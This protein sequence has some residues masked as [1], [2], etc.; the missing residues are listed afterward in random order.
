MNDKKLFSLTILG[1]IILSLLVGCTE[2]EKLGDNVTPPKVEKITKELTRHGDTRID[3]YYWLNERENPK[4]INYLEAENAYR[5]TVMRLTENLQENLYREIV[6]RIKQDDMSVPYLDNGYYY[7]SRYEKGKEYPIYARKKETLQADEEITLNVPEIAKGHDYYQVSGLNVSE[8]NNLIA[9]GV[10]TVSRR[11][12]DIYFKDLQNGKLL[13]DLLHNTS[14]YVVWA[15]DNKT[16]FY[17]IKDET[18][19]PHKL[20]K[21]ILGQDPAKDVMVF[22]EKDNTFSLSVSKT[23]TNKFIEIGSSHTLSTEVNLIDANHPDKPYKIFQKRE[24][25]HEYTIYHHLDKFYILTNWMAKNFRL[26]ETEEGKTDKKY[27]I[28]VLP[29]HEDILLQNVTVFKDYLALG[30]RKNGIRQLHVMNL[31]DQSD[32][33]LEFDEESY[34]V[35][36]STNRIFDTKTLRYLY[37]SMTTPGSTFDYDMTS[38]E[39]TLLKREEVGGEFNPDDYRSERVWAVAR[40]DTKVPISLV[41]HRNTKKDGNSPLL[42]YG[43]GSYGSNM[44]PSFSSSRLSL[45]NRGFIYAVVHIRGGSEMGR[46]WY[47]DGKLLKKKNTFYDFIDCAEYLVKEKYTNPEK[48]FAAGGSAGGLLV[49]AVANMAPDL[50]KGILASVPWVD[51]VTTM[52]DESI[53]LTTV[54]FDEWGNPKNKEYYDYMLSYSPY[55]NVEAKDYPALYVTTGLHDSQVQYFEPAKWVAKLRELKTDKNLILL[56]VDMESGHGGTTGRFKRFNRTARQY[57]FLL[58]QLDVWE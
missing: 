26:M 56:E 52:L 32:H 35:Y 54:E 4:V 30:E 31:A 29:H 21:H 57:V 51:V 8:D 34:V 17:T 47:E 37:T 25:D 43:Y 50:F 11:R 42:L 10:D 27:W 46:Y 3:N 1:I 23:K 15:N 22:H 18:L 40:D 9:F 53:P 28:E 12:Y 41:Y 20:M 45:L 58:T 2:N 5:E 39:K 16:V 44:E 14:G 33:Y 19:R 6:G 49:G 55:D 38:K 24:K 48:L 36:S 13:P 7:Y